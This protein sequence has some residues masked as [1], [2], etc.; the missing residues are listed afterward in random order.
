[1][2][3]WGLSM[4]HGK[5][6]E[7][8]VPEGAE[9][10]AGTEV[11]EVETEKITGCVESSINGTL[12]RHVAL[13]GQ[14][15]SI[16][17]LLA[18]IADR[19]VSDDEIDRFVESFLPEGAGDESA[20]DDLASEFAEVGGRRLRYLKQGEGGQPAVLI[21]GFTGSLDNAELHRGVAADR[22]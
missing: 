16:G 2:P 13:V 18:V 15:V 1:M 17:G 4:T 20:S 8:L 5:V 7:W 14:D 3:K 21:H 19:S 11:L 10:F 22:L 9:V 12:R 6:V